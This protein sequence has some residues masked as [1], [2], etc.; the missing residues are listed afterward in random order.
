MPVYKKKYAVVGVSNRAHGMFMDSLL[1]E[2]SSYGQ[3]VAMLDKDRGRM[4]Q[5]NSSR[6]V[7]IP[8]YLPDEFDKMVQKTSPNVIIVACQD[9]MH[10]HYIIKALEKDLDV[11]AEKPLTNTEQKCAAIYKAAMKS[12][13]KVTVTF[14][15]R[16]TTQ[17]TKTRELIAAGKIGRVISVDLNWYLDTYHGSSYFQRWNRLRDISGGLSVHKSCHHLDLVQWWIG[18]K[19]MEVY[20]YGG[21]NFYG[22]KGVHNP[23]K[24]EQTGDGRTCPT[25]D[26][27]DKC[28]YYMRWYRDEYR[29]GTTDKNP[30]EGYSPRQ[31][32]YDPAIDIEDTYGAVIRY[33]QGAILTY[34]LNG[35]MPY[36]GFSLGINGTEGRLEFKELHAKDRLPYETANIN[37]PIVYIP[38][39]GGREKIDTITLGGGHGGGDPLLRDELFIGEDKLAPVCRKAGLEEGIDVVLT[40]IAMYKSVLEHRAISMEDLRKQIFQQSSPIDNI[41]KL[42]PSTSLPI[43]SR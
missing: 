27:K 6:K 30:Y 16:Y 33:G 37:E 8:C 40:G 38:M 1:N 36:E 15:C 18:Q 29:S 14:N 9:G 11:I 5:Y 19:P 31:C 17:A 21:L 43:L 12:K 2:Y 35:S 20:A 10:H 3:L 32:I 23:L 34:S 42:T 4:E 28:K 39:F 13:G 24:K 22:P 7:N 26:V 25:C 41:R